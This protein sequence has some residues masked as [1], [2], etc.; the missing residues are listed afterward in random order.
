MDYRFL[1]KMF[2]NSNESGSN[3]KEHK[4]IE[5]QSP[6]C[7]RKCFHESLERSCET[8]QAE[9]EIQEI[10]EKV[11]VRNRVT[12]NLNKKFLRIQLVRLTNKE[13]SNTKDCDS[14]NQQFSKLYQTVKNEKNLI[15]KDKEYVCEICEKKFRRQYNLKIHLKCV[16]ESV[17]PY[18]CSL[19]EYKSAT[20][21]VLKTHKQSVHEKTTSYDCEK[22]EK[23]FSR[24]DGL[25]IHISAIHEKKYFPCLI[26][27]KEN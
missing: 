22:C 21:S 1:G 23:S 19:C 10:K 13:I 4:N 18:Q 12:I 2:R 14:K 20:K 9:Q 6:K 15:R 26:C 24:K 11:Q 5:T 27:D 7:L 25:D 3:S 8:N 17:K 16:H